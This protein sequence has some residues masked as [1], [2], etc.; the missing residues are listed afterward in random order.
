MICRKIPNYRGV[1]TSLSF[2]ESDESR[3]HINMLR[4]TPATILTKIF[5]EIRIGN[6]ISPKP[7]D[8]PSN[9]AVKY[10]I[11]VTMTQNQIMS[12]RRKFRFNIVMGFIGS[13]YTRKNRRKVR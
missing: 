13:C 12:M 6:F 10:R 3:C 8:V 4:C 11:V 9:Y 7:L 5:I 2:N 1:T